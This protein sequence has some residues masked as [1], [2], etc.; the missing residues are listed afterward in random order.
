MTSHHALHLLAIATLASV[1]AT[2]AAAQ[3]S[4]Y[5]LGLGV[6]QTRSL[7]DERRMAEEQLGASPAITAFQRDR[8]DLGYKV[9]GGYQFNRYF[10]VEGGFIDLGRF[11]YHASTTPDGTLDG[12]LRVQ[13]AN[14]DLVGTLPL[15]ESFSLLGRIGGSYVKTRNN[16]DGQGAA[17]V[18]DARPSQREGNPKVGVGL[19]YEFNRSM[20]LRTDYERYRIADAQGH[21]GNVD[22]LSLSLVFPFG[23][24]P[25]AAPRAAAPAYVPP[26]AMAPA[27]PPVVVAPLPPAEVVAF[28][29][30]A[31]R[32]RV[33]F[34]AESVFGF[35]RS[36]VA[37]AGM[38]ALDGFARELDGTEYVVINVEGHTDRIGSTA[39]N[40]TLSLERAE[41]VKAYL[42]SHGR[43]DA[44][45][46]AVVGKSESEPITQAG[47]CKGSQPTAK[48]IAC[49]Q[50]DRRV[51]LEVVGTR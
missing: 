19:Q 9:F 51:E 4:Y 15:S 40:Q 20:L 23:R 47:D 37:P 31:A 46:I 41:A 1:A 10:G 16:V 39:Y 32:R 34:S 49:L 12:R 24:T 14:L 6:G 29:P 22:M 48:L 35:D 7:L 33:S 42:V 45:K 3:D 17:T 44:A 26:L 21:R 38:V 2:P 11:T 25:M 5:Y 18:A 36:T 43:I 8:N 30:P 28:A 50:P 13:G 27:P